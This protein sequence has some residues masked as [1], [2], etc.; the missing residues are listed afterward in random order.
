MKYRF[1]KKKKGRK[2]KGGV[3]SYLSMQHLSWCHE[4]V[5]L[6]KKKL[7]TLKAF[8]A[9]IC[10]AE[11]TLSKAQSLIAVLGL[12]KYNILI[13]DFKLN[14]FYIISQRSTD[15]CFKLFAICLCNTQTS[16]SFKTPHKHFFKWRPLLGVSVDSGEENG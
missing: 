4:T 14:F 2:K 13:T 15:K 16:S 9:N 11:V 7:M 5:G 12:I 8:K 3:G 1:A 10:P 6:E